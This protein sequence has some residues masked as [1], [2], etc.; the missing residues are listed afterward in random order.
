MLSK[1]S[2]GV[3][4]TSQMTFLNHGKSLF[5]GNFSVLKLNTKMTKVDDY[6][7]VTN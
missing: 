6:S 4:M 5:E 7:D 2:I 3:S 1:P